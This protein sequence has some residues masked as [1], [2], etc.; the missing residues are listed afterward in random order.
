V[1]DHLD[2]LRASLRGLLSA[3]APLSAVRDTALAGKPRDTALWA[4]LASEVGVHGLPFAEADGGAGAGQAELVVALEETAQVLLDQ[5]LFPSILAG[6]LVAETVTGSARAELLPAIAAG[7]LTATFAVVPSLLTDRQIVR[8]VPEAQHSQVLLAT[9]GARVV[10]I[11]L[12]APGVT[13]RPTEALDPTRPCADVEFAAVEFAAVEF[14]AVDV[15]AENAQEGF[16]RWHLRALLANAAEQAGV[17]RTSL[18]LATE[19]AKLRVQFDKP[20]GAQQAIQHLLADVLA[21]TIGS[22]A[23][24]RKA[25]RAVDEGSADAAELVTV[26]AAHSSEAVTRATEA[27]IQVHGG[28]GFTWEHDAHLLY[29]RANASAT[30]FGG[31]AAR[32]R[33]LATILQI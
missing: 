9:D 31:A 24:V 17:C 6:Q 8:G 1:T 13:V 18:T 23:S 10:R 14:A 16:A 27:L 20:I 25:A 30:F 2:D 26:A 33:E 19:Y 22:E 15:L 32:R 3:H 29:R 7:E 12:E 5:P 11:D 4:R 28:I 21:A